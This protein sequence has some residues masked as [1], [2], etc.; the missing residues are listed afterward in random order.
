MLLL[1]FRERGRTWLLIHTDASLDRYQRG[2]ERGQQ[3]LLRCPDSI[4]GDTITLSRGPIPADPLYLT[5]RHYQAYYVGSRHEQLFRVFPYSYSLGFLQA[6]MVLHLWTH[7]CH[8][9]GEKTW[10]Q[11]PTLLLD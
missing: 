4:Y 3:H 7:I 10:P 8:L 11:V 5:E 9:Q 1:V 2:H 6:T